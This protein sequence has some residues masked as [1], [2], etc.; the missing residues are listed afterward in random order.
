MSSEPLERKLV[1]ILYADVAGY[2]RLTGEDEEGTHRAL[3]ARLDA[4]TASI[5]KHN[6]TVLHF[7][8]D[9]VLA[10]FATVSEALICAVAVQQD[11]KRRNKALPEERKVQFRIGVNLGE[12]IVDRGEIYGD[13]VNV[14]ARLESLAKPGGIC[15]SESVRTAIGNNLP[16]DYEFRGEQ[17][18]KNIAE[19]VRAY[20][21]EL[22]PGATLPA[23]SVRPQAQPPIRHPILA[24][25]AAVALL[26]GVGVIAWWQPWQ[27]REKPA[28]L[29]RTAF[30]L[31]D[32]PSIAVLPFQNM[33]G[34]PEQDYFS[35]GM[36][37]D[38]ITDLSKI[39]GLFVIARNSV[40]T[41]KDVP[42]KIR[43]VGREFGVRYVLEGSVRKAGGKVRITAQL[44]DATNEFH[45][46]ADRFDGDLKDVFAL[47]DE[48]TAKIISALELKLTESERES[49]ARKY[50][51]S[52]EAY[53]Y[54]LRGLE[55][56]SRYNK[57][58]N[59]NAREFYERAIELDPTFARAYANLA[60]T[61]ASEFVD[62]WSDAPEQS[63]QQAH[64][65]AEKAIALDDSLPQV[66][67]VMGEV[68]LFSK[69]HAAAVREVENVIALDPNSADAYALLAWTL[70]YAGTPKDSVALM[71]KAM[72]R[73]PRYPFA[74]LFG[75]GEIYFT[76]GRYDKA[77]E[78]F[79]KALERNPV[80][81]R[82]RMW[83]AASYAHAG[84]IDDAEWE[85]EQLVTLDPDFSLQRM[86]QVIP[87]KDPAHLEK[88]LDGLREAGLV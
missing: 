46:W 26:V 64:E 38:L 10:D 32:K 21:A 12:V 31:P 5:E 54:F 45:I 73:N 23:P 65:L 62:G 37:E 76:L 82:T 86:Q 43:D 14:A 17:E 35:D 88:L 49:L 9:A 40:F 55:Q 80:A 28:S 8:G 51:N 4:I 11:L 1:A 41:Y 84:R 83:L 52:L 72:R 30:P 24:T 19:P 87:Y 60:R 69:H 70:H 39:S 20:S 18:V 61:Y 22:K 48:V 2:S 15:I 36:T 58:D 68:H 6:G 57:E 71:E 56:F 53:D 67:W 7:A 33:S 47:Q 25:V 50:T 66:H 42:V 85:V 3:S 16:L 59:L 13:G 63:L 78:T 44:I 77:I 81:Q 27:T 74:Y 29:E 34:E 75:L 79:E